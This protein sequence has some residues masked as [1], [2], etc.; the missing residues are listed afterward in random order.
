MITALAVATRIIANP[1]SNVFQKRLADA[2]AHPLFIITATHALLTIM[3]LPLLAGVHLTLLTADFWINM[4]VSAMLAIVGNSLL[5]FALRFGDLSVLGSINAYKAILSLVLGIFLIGEIPSAAGLAGVLL[6][7]IGSYFVVDRADGQPYRGAFV[8]FFRERGVRYRFAAL[9]CSAT[10]AVFLKRA[11]LESSALVVFLLWAAL[12]LAVALVFIAI[13]LG[14]R[15]RAE[16]TLLRQR[17]RTFGWLAVT[18]GLMQVTTLLTFGVMQVGYSLALFQL[19]TLIS[20]FLGYRYFQEQ[21]IRR[22]L[23]GSGVMIAGAVLIALL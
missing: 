21:N 1:V 14:Q 17:W 12:G 5:V 15:V 3:A 19:S 23:F 6:I 9:A 4:V 7:L 16:M 13:L 8:S 18:A 22:R 20:V 10:E 2:T 11:V